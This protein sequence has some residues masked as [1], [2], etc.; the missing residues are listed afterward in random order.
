MGHLLSLATVVLHD[1][2]LLTN[3]LPI[4]SALNSKRF[5]YKFFLN[6]GPPSAGQTTK[7]HQFKSLVQAFF[8]AFKN[9][10]SMTLRLKL[11]DLHKELKTVVMCWPWM[12]VSY[13][14]LESEAHSG[15]AGAEEHPQ[16]WV[17]Q[18]SIFNII[19]ILLKSLHT[20]NAVN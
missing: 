18:S 12:H 19:S 2:L 5:T 6:N 9:S 8:P 4:I 16:T 14:A 17:S 3:F 11:V 7:I 10:F 13:Q 1:M 15:G 20:L